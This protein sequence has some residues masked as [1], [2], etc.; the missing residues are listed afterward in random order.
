MRTVISRNPLISFVAIAYGWT[1]IF[2][3]LI[4]RCILFPLLGLFGPAVAAI[5]V[6]T[7]MRQSSEAWGLKNRFRLSPGLLAWCML[8]A[9][10]P[11]ALLFPVGLL[12]T[13]WSG[14]CDFELNQP[15]LLSIV[16]AVLIIGEEVGWRGFFLPHL[17]QRYSPV[18]S[19]LIVGIIWAV[20][21]LPNFLMPSFPHYGSPFSAFVLMTIAF[22]ML[23]TWFH[24]RTKGSLVV[25]VIFHT[26]LN[27]FSLSGVE[28]SIEYSLKAV[29]YAFA[30]FVAYGVARP[31]RI[32]RG[33]LVK[34]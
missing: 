22:S 19:S 2:A 24:F 8:A 20:W 27:L 4:D 17:L 26:A 21:H 29:V 6:R 1:W 25:A 7:A 16:V 34:E 32:A 30:A 5:I 14:A 13:W 23:F 33:V 15:S 12:Q 28:P 18:T 31:P 11:F 3:A 9:F 10:L